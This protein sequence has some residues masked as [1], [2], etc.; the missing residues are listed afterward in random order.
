MQD[1]KE[2]TTKYPLLSKFYEYLDENVDQTI[3]LLDAATI[4]HISQAI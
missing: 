1:L 3:S 4:C 2:L